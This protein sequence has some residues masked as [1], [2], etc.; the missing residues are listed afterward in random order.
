VVVFP[1]VAFLISGTFAALLLRQFANR[2]RVQQL[3]WGVALAEFAVAT[4]AVALAVGGDG[5]DPA[6]YRLYWLFGA[7]LNVPWLAVGSVALLRNR[8]LTAGALAGVAI[9][10]AWA[11][12]K[13]FG[14]SVALTIAGSKDIPR[15]H[16]AWRGHGDVRTLADWYSIPAYFVVVAIAVWTSRKRAGVAPPRERVRANALIAAGVTIVAVGST[17][18]A[19]LAQGAAFSV[20][21]AVGVSVMF[22][23]FL[24]ASR[25]ARF[26]V[27][28]P[29]ES[30][31]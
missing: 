12:V 17:A 25:P 7:L 22:A 26:H 13:V 18:L 11:V 23:G 31:T 27:E 2:K 30:P 10:T 20:T 16:V 24:L 9:G 28:S 29:G 14:T 19:R 8:A 3:A 6:L 21:L 1:V 4:A 5:W 15:G